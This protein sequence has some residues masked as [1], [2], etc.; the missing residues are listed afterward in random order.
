MDVGSQ[1]PLHTHPVEEAWVV[2]AGELV[3]RVGEETVVVPAGAV[4]RVPPEVPHAVHNEGSG[5]ARAL[6]AAP[7]NR[8]SFYTNGTTYLE[9]VAP[10]AA[11]GEEAPPGA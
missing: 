3:V 7:W 10:V 1:I 6:T 2:T 8:A 4:V 5:V 11:S 9:G